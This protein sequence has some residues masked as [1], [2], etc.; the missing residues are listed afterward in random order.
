MSA[1]TMEYD[2]IGFLMTGPK[3]RKDFWRSKDFYVPSIKRGICPYKL[4]NDLLEMKFVEKI[5]YSYD[6]QWHYTPTRWALAKKFEEEQLKLES[7]TIER[8]KS[9]DEITI[10]EINRLKSI[11]V[12]NRTEKNE[13]HAEKV[14]VK[15][16]ENRKSIYEMVELFKKLHEE[17]IKHEK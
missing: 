5:P 16:A 11:G 14:T 6:S 15:I 10:E 12:K 4:L 1:L 17:S 2:V 8:E 9:I 13:V 7:E 3:S